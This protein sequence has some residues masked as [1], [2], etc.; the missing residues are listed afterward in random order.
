MC[1]PVLSVS[2]VVVVVTVSTVVV[3]VDDKKNVIFGFGVKI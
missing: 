2:I 3:G 1:L